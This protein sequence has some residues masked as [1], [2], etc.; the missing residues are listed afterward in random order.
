MKTRMI[1]PFFAITFLWG[2]SLVGII[3]AFPERVEALFGP[4]TNTNPLFI[5][6]VY[7]PA[8]AAI[9]VVLWSGGLS[10][11]KRFLSRLL[12]WRVHWGW[13]AFIL[14][15][16]PALFYAG[17]AMKGTFTVEAFTVSSAG[18]LPAIAFM[19]VLGPM[20]EL[21]WRGVAQPLIQRRVAP[22]WAAII[23]GTIWGVWHLPAFLLS[24]VVHS[25]WA[26]PPFFIGAIAIS[27]IITPLFNASRGSILLPALMHWQ[28]N[29]P[30]FP[31]AAPYD[32]YTFGAAAAVLVWVN[33]KTMFTRAGSVTEVIPAP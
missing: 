3:L 28:L 17:I 27:V 22:F 21:G 18:L 13:Y 30:A 14:L 25:G 9:S 6:A 31:N 29:N 2:W 19:M 20:E 8:V 4:L 1:F 10:G 24:G 33:R 11:L 5:L 15:G 26:F 16:V 12:L 7:S 32:T 23:I